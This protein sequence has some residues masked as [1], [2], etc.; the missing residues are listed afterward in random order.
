MAQGSVVATV[1]NEAG[2]IGELLASLA[3]LAA[4]AG[5]LRQGLR[6]VHRLFRL[7][8]QGAQRL[9]AWTAL[10][11]LLRGARR[12]ALLRQWASRLI[13]AGRSG[14]ETA[15]ASYELALAELEAGGD[16]GRARELARTALELMP[17]ELRQY[18]L[19]AL[20]RIHVACGEYRD[21]VEYLEVA[22][23]LSASPTILTQ[24]GLALLGVGEGERAREVLQRARRGAVRDL[25]TDV[26]SHLVRVSR[27]SGR[28]R[29][30]S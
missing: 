14:I 23:T 15:L 2:S 24:L 29:R 27:L 6:A 10:L 21:A 5:R 7:E 4:S 17:S 19:A 20:G 22:A 25:K 11:E 13:E 18:P 1:K 8:P 16:L 28:G 3:L 9:A 26:L 30:R 12:F